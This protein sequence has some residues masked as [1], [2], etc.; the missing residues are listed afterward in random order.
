ML[1]TSQGDYALRYTYNA[2]AEY[3]ARFGTALLTDAAEGGFARVRN[4]VWAGLL[5]AK[6][7]PHFTL[8]E[9]GALLEDAILQGADMI[10]LHNAVLEAIND[11]V[12]IKGLVTRGKERKASRNSKN[13]KRKP[14]DS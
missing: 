13:P 14:S 9:A 10:D 7:N 5:D 12:F 1:H 6:K 11:A 3:E 4:L 8:E 2:L